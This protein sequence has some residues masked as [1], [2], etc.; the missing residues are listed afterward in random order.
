MVI[1]GEYQGNPCLPFSIDDPYYHQS[2]RSIGKSIRQISKPGG[3]AQMGSAHIRREIIWDYAAS[4][5]VSVTTRFSGPLAPREGFK[6]I[7]ISKPHCLIWST[8]AQIW[9]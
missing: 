6:T 1:E 8:L 2:Q 3:M 9:A 5:A 7:L 4:I